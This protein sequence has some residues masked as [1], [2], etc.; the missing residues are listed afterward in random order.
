MKK[1]KGLAKSQTETKKQQVKREKEEDQAL[2]KAMA[3]NSSE[4][5]KSSSQPAAAPSGAQ[6]VQK[7]QKV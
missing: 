1:D 6:V 4:V 7:E 2:S 3:D 5:I